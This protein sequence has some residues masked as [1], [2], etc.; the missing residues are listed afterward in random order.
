MCA[1]P[2]RS[3]HQKASS[4]LSDTNQDVGLRCAVST[5]VRALSPATSLKSPVEASTSAR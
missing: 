1:Q 3:D 4:V 2:S 5:H